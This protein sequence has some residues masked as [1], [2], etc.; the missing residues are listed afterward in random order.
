MS[1][2]VLFVGGGSG[3]HVFPMLAVAGA[4]G[5]VAPGVRAVFVGTTRG[6]EKRAVP[7]AGYELELL[8]TVPFR[9]RGVRGAAAGLWGV[10]RCMPQA[11]SLVRRYRPAAVFSAGGYAAVPLA[12]AARASRRPLA[13]MEPNSGPGLA[14]RLCGPLAGRVYSSFDE[15]ARYFR[16][17]R[18]LRTGVALRPGFQPAPYELGPDGSIRLLVLGGSQG[19]TM[20]NQ[21]FPLALAN[22]DL[23]LKTLH[24]AGR[25]NLE[26]TAA[27]YEAAGV[28]GARVVE[29]IEDMPTALRQADLVLSR[30]GAG[31]I[32]EVCAVGRP[33]ILVP[34][35]ISGDHQLHNA[36]AVEAAGASRCIPAGTASADTLRQALSELCS[37]RSRMR[38]MATRAAQWGRPDAADRVAAD[39]A[40]FA[41]LARKE[42]A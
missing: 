19:A 17:D 37:D 38:Q 10:A 42:A 14:N 35:P 26:S 6:M 8:E 33:S 32:A 25:G 40:E 7:E 29:F 1:E 11:L 27:A 21:Q 3:G 15:T 36:R 20:L 39:L 12:L 16:A 5:R 2:V 18:V 41:G 28:T 24:Q 4:L 23:P 31:A 9:G 30:A 13:I 22:L 34:L